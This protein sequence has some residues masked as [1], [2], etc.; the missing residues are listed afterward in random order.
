M[1]GIL[2]EKHSAGATAVHVKEKSGDCNTFFLILSNQVTKKE[3][4]VSLL[5]INK[6]YVT[7]CLLI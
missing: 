1:S 4:I 7:E 5:L 2:N 3:K 6:F